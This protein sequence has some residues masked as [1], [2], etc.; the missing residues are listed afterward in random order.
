MQEYRGPYAHL[1]NAV[2]YANPSKPATR[3]MR[4][5]TPESVL[6]AY[7]WYVEARKTFHRFGPNVVPAAICE[8]TNEFKKVVLESDVL[9]TLGIEPERIREL[10]ELVGRKERDKARDMVEEFLSEAYRKRYG[11][12]DPDGETEYILPDGRPNSP[13]IMKEI[14]HY[15]SRRRKYFHLVKSGEVKG[16]EGYE[17]ILDPDLVDALRPVDTLFAFFKDIGLGVEESRRAMRCQE[18]FPENFWKSIC[19]YVLGKKEYYDAEKNETYPGVPMVMSAAKIT[20]EFDPAPDRL[21][22][23]AERFVNENNFRLKNKRNGQYPP[24]S[25]EL[26]YAL[27]DE[28]VLKGFGFKDDI[29]RLVMSK[30]LPEIDESQLDYVLCPR[31]RKEQTPGYRHKDGS[32]EP[33]RTDI[34]PISD[35][36]RGEL[37]YRIG[38]AGKETP[39]VKQAIEDLKERKSKPLQ[40]D[41][42]I[43]AYIRRLAACN[44]ATV[45]DKDKPSRERGRYPADIL[46]ATFHPELIEDAKM[47]AMVSHGT[48][49]PDYM[50]VLKE[51]VNLLSDDAPLIQLGV[52]KSSLMAAADFAKK[53]PDMSTFQLAELAHDPDNI[54]INAGFTMMLQRQWSAED[55]KDSNAFWDRLSERQSDSL[56]T[57]MGMTILGK[58][59][60]FKA[61][62]PDMFP[63]RENRE[64]GAGGTK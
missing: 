59:K 27:H 36:V 58:A 10:K 60:E 49:H 18:S 38:F 33:F 50:D 41:A 47:N 4:P 17:E 55:T 29:V 3:D 46:V 5:V 34:P 19:K 57:L 44:G 56:R 31:A 43:G 1:D 54:W 11:E 12:F 45:P 21:H 22:C 28:D 64:N 63:R 8:F 7:S 13:A 48:T 15:D 32:V 35:K 6:V 14:R 9:Y 20:H 61:A 40:P 37:S 51:W 42:G 39:L 16:K 23:L 62:H 25:D 24:F 52:K 26:L 53:H 2:Y 30:R